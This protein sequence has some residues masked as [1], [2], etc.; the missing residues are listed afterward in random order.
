MNTG[1]RVRAHFAVLD[2]AERQHSITTAMRALLD[3]DIR[4]EDR[5]GL[6]DVCLWR[7]TG[8][9][10]RYKFATR[11]RSTH[12]LGAAP[13]EINHEHVVERRWLFWTASQPTPPTSIVIWS[14]LSPAS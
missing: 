5:R 11:Y 7:Y 14:W 6:R 2:V 4:P 9:E 1:A 13:V 12:V 3:A 8:F 10:T